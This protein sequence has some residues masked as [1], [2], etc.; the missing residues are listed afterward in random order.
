MIEF[1]DIDWGRRRRHQRRPVRL[2]AT[3]HASGRDLPAIT[4]NISPGGAFL[5]VELPESEDLV[6]ATIG[7]PNGKE[8]HVRA[9]ICWRREAP[10]AGVGIAFEQ[11]L[12]GDA[13]GGPENLS[14]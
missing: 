10:L 7:L 4:E 13:G 11:F 6:T 2:Q 3:I 8:M 1:D 5:Q 9:R 14:T 12:P